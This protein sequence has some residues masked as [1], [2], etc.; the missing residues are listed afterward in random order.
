MST[1]GG[2]KTIWELV[3]IFNFVW[4]RV[5]VSSLFAMHTTKTEP[6]FFD[7]SKYVF[8]PYLPKQS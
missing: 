6:K 8:D 1:H 5:S 4:D 2:Q 3:L 7:Y